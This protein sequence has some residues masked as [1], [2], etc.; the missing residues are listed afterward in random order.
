MREKKLS[1]QDIAAK[2]KVSATTVSFVLNGKAKEHRVSDQVVEKILKYVKATGYQPNAVARSL[3]TGKTRTIG[4]MIEDISNPF[5]AAIARLIEDKAYDNGY[6]IIYCST[7]NDTKKA[8]ELIQMFEDRGV[9]GYIIAAP[10]GMEA[11]IK[12]LIQKNRPIVLFDRYF[13]KIDTDYVVINNEESAFKATT[14]CIKQGFKKIA[15]VTIPSGLPQ[16]K[17]RLDGYLAALKKNKLKPRVREIQYSLESQMPVA[18]IKKFLQENSDTDAVI[19]ATNYL[20]VAGLEA[21]QVL[22]YQVPRDLAVISFDDHILFKLSK[23]S[24]TAIAQPVELIADHVINILL[25]KL[26]HPEKH[27]VKSIRVATS[28]VLRQS[29]EN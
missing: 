25:S 4:L 23:P 26:T 7:N 13:P 28:M 29:S 9:D 27:K 20:G 10:Q 19:F 24:V 5:F 15:F 12:S 17:E 11:E 6:K 1:L 14:Y 22:N 21:I 2:L 16:M 18:E 3:R 8:K